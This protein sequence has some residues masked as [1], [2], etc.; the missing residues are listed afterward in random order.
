MTEDIA[1]PFDPPAVACKKVSAPWMN[2]SALVR[3]LSSAQRSSQMPLRSRAI[4]TCATS[5]G[6]SQA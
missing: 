1:L 3:K 5:C 4:S 2:G 6:I